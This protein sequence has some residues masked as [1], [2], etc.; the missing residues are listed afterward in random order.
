MLMT[1]TEND[2]D[3]IL[4][5]FKERIVH[6]TFTQSVTRS[7]S[8]AALSKLHKE[9]EIVLDQAREASISRMTNMACMDILR[10][11]KVVIGFKD[12][13]YAEHEQILLLQHNRQYQW[14]LVEAYEAFEDY[15][16]K[17]YAY[18]GY[19]DNDFWKVKNFEGK[20]A[21]EIKKLDLDWFVE[22]AKN[23]KLEER[24]LK[25]KLKQINAK[26]PSLA[27]ILAIRKRDDPLDIDYEFTTILVSKLRH[28]IV[29]ARGYANK[30]KFIN[31]RLTEYPLVNV[32]KAEQQG[33]VDVMSLLF[34]NRRH[35][36]LIALLEVHDPT[37]PMMFV[38]RLGDL[39]ARVTSYA[40]LLHGL[41]KS[42]LA[43][44]FS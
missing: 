20:S 43:G 23:G 39:L 5:E 14:L 41:V 6:V 35:E 37:Q 21:D 13:S 9:Y 8:K 30:E 12:A 2:L 29:H 40:M 3:N 32:P 25:E 22:K 44:K 26:I 24:G 31:S 19:L 33:Y 4:E 18:S 28:Q 27:Q 36:D 42:H 7:V 16:E 34:E 17:L 1:I 10:N 38:D 11:Q 15:L